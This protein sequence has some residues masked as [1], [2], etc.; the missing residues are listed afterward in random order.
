MKSLSPSQ[1]FFA[2][3]ANVVVRPT[4]ARLGLN[5]GPVAL[6]LLLGTAA[7]ESG[8]TYL[9]QYPTGPALGLWQIEP[10]THQ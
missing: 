1:I 8:G 9:A 5:D 3:L 4:L 6:N 7:Q 2:Q 10:N